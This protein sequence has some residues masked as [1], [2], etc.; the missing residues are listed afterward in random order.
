MKPLK[1]FEQFINENVLNDTDYTELEQKAIAKRILSKDNS[2]SPYEAENLAK[3]YDWLKQEHGED[4]EAAADEIIKYRNEEREEKM[5]NPLLKKVVDGI[6][7]GKLKI[8]RGGEKMYGNLKLSITEL[9]W[10]RNFEDGFTIDV[11]DG[12]HGSHIGQIDL[13]ASTNWKPE[14]TEAF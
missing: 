7:S 8:L 9:I 6:N 10:A 13:T 14:I 1:K 4:Y 5:N 3:S 2:F 11:Y 12:K